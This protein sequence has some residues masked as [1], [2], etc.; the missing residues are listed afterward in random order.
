PKYSYF[1]GASTGGRQGLSEAQR[2]PEDYDG[3]VAG[4]PAI[5]WDKLH[6]AQMWP[7]IVM[8]TANNRL[9]AAKLR[10]ATKAFI[11]ACDEVDGVKD[12]IVED[13][14]RCSF[15]P[16]VLVG[17]DV[18]GSK[19]T[20]ADVDVLRKIWDGPRAKDNSFLWYGPSKGADLTALAG[21]QPFGITM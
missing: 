13:P 19:F 4:C 21:A 18:G 9:S 2:F 7:Q 5:N 11:D 16:K 6:V 12:G 3:I 15:D 17:K 8:S 20:E 1:V 10:A 14:S